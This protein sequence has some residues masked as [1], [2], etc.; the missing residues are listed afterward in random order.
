MRSVTRGVGCGGGPTAPS[1]MASGAR[2]SRAARGAIATPR[3]EILAGGWGAVGGPGPARGRRARRGR[4]CG[5][6]AP[7]WPSTLRWAD[8]RAYDGI[9]E[10]PRVR[11]SVCPTAWG[12]CPTRTASATPASTRTASATARACSS[13]R[14]ATS[15][16]ATGRRGSATAT[17]SCAPSEAPRLRASGPRTNSRRPPSS[18]HRR[19]SKTLDRGA[20]TTAAARPPAL[21]S[22]RRC[23]HGC[24]G[25]RRAQR[26]GSLVR[27]AGGSTRASGAVA[28]RQR[29]V[30]V[31][32]GRPIPRRWR[33]G[34]RTASAG[35]SGPMAARTTAAGSP[36]IRRRQAAAAAAA[37]GA[38]SAAGSEGGR[39]ARCATAKGRLKEASGVVYEGQWRRGER[40]SHGK[41]SHPSGGR[42]RGSGPTASAW[43]P[44]ARRWR[45]ARRGRASGAP[46][47]RRGAAR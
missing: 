28:P 22:E 24:V 30:H 1:T 4:A 18:P 13:T 20:S 6:A 46:T 37:P 39:S 21:L 10:A 36:P 7:P 17:A 11:S 12:R 3:A 44:A 26:R 29:D 8:G 19:P 31:P 41:S 45:R 34:R 5:R 43:A 9:V 32:V 25:R 42:T 16:T 15:T 27:A 47:C 23:V 38:L 14:A 33:Y 40:D 2:G 35:S